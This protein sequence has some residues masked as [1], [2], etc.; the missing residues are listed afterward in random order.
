[1]MD[2]KDTC[3]TFQEELAF[4]ADDRPQHTELQEHLKGCAHC[5]CFEKSVRE[6]TKRARLER[7]DPPADL[8]K[9]TMK[10]LAPELARR[11]HEGFWL[12]VRLAIVGLV[13]LPIIVGINGFLI[14]VVYSSLGSWLSQP[15]ATMVAYVVAASALL[16]LSLTYGALPLLAEWGVELRQRCR[17]LVTTAAVPTGLE[18]TATGRSK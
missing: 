6:L 16:G 4:C 1:M 3:R 5:S 18:A 12:R 7:F 10:H 17:D 2:R 13:S 11:T 15:L 8:V 9:R 14:W